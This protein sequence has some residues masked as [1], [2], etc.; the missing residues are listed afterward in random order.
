LVIFT[1]FIDIVDQGNF[2]DSVSPSLPVALQPA[3]LEP[4]SIPV[5]NSHT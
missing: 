5:M 2:H 1:L 4:V 3:H